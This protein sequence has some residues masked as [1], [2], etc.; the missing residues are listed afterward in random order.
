MS[1]L[2]DTLCEKLGIQVSLEDPNYLIGR[3][4]FKKR[5]SVIEQTIKNLDSLCSKLSYKSPEPPK[6]RSNFLPPNFPNEDFCLD[7][8]DPTN[9]LSISTE[10]KIVEGVIIKTVKVPMLNKRQKE[11]SVSE[12]SEESDKSS[13]SFEY[14]E[15]EDNNSYISPQD[16]EELAR[17]LKFNDF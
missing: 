15:E 3:E 9:F 14:E 5:I 2:I 7:R 6:W 12:E 1:N 10:T 16:F 17:V 4:S 8:D 13:S 11:N